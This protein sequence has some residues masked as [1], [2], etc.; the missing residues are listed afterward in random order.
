MFWHGC[1]LFKDVSLQ[2][3][4]IKLKIF[5]REVCTMSSNNSYEDDLAEV[6]ENQKIVFTG[7]GGGKKRARPTTIGKKR[8]GGAQSW[9]YTIALCPKG[10][11]KKCC[12]TST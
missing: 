7:G 4:K 10:C 9:G 12:K 3:L 8:M 11:S 2:F 5:Y 1:F 6:W